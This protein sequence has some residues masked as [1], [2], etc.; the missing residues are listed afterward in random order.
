MNN[1]I[2][3]S[4]RTNF[5]FAVPFEVQGIMLGLFLGLIAGLFYYQYY[6]RHY[7]WWYTVGAGM[8]SAVISLKVLEVVFRIEAGSVVLVVSQFV[9]PAIATL[10]VNQYLYSHDRK[11]RHRKNVREARA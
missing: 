3:L 10:V 4:T 11:Y 1:L 9:V 6:R 7:Y 5:D 8:L 2:T